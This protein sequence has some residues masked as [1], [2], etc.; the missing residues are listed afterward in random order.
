M[1]Y[2]IASL[3]II[4]FMVAIVILRIVPVAK[5]ALHTS[6]GVVTMLS[7][8]ELDDTHR[9]KELQR[10]SVSLLGNF[11]S[12]TLRGAIALV[13]SYLSI[14]LA[15]LAGLAGLQDVFD[16]LSS[17]EAFVTATVILTLAWLIWKKWLE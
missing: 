7:N 15:D 12:I 6:R 16:L 4:V 2:V 8:P 3:A 1:V 14:Y 10:A 17:W 5:N 9:E 11:L 13:L